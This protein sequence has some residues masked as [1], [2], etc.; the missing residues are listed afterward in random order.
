MGWLTDPGDRKGSDLVAF[1]VG[2]FLAL[3]IVC[4]LVAVPLMWWLAQVLR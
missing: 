4:A 1:R 2:N 3:L